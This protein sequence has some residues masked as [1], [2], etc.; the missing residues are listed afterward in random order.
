MIRG[1]ALRPS[2]GVRPIGEKEEE[3]KARMRHRTPITVYRVGFHRGME[4]SVEAGE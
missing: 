1:T 2:I 3:R 4:S